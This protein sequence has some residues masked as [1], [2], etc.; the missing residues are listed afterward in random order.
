MN[1]N[2]CDSSLIHQ[3]M[4]NVEDCR[5]LHITLHCP[6]LYLYSGLIESADKWCIL[7]QALTKVDNIESFSLYY[8]QDISKL[9]R[10]LHSP[11]FKVPLQ[12]SEVV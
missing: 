3:A 12:Y 6:T 2:K 1:M 9:D 8:W 10:P 7:Q 5:L 4:E 11:C